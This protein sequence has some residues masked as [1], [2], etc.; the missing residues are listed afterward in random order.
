MQNNVLGHHPALQSALQAEVHRFR[1]FQQ[2]LA[3]AHH[4]SRVRVPDPRGK[5][6]ERPRHAGVRIGAEKNFARPG[7]ALLRQGGV[8]HA[9]VMRS[10]LP[11]E[12]PL[13]RVEL[14]RAVRV[15]NHVVEIGQVLLLDELRARCPRSGWTAS[16]P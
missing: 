1:H 11:V 16:P 12:H 14:P 6:V 7:M 10:I 8:A 5:L 3:R 4:K 9:R 15:V 2:Q 13:G